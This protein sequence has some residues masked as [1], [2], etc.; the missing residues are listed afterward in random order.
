MALLQKQ[1][2]LTP[3]RKSWQETGKLQGNGGDVMGCN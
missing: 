1:E 3:C 2:L